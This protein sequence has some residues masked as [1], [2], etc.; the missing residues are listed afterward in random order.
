MMNYD[1]L[2]KCGKNFFFYKLITFDLWR[3]GF[4]ILY[5]LFHVLRDRVG[6]ITVEI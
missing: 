2:T 6:Q 1:T 3:S 5:V 4:N